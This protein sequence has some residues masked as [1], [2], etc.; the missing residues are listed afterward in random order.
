[1]RLFVN[2]IFRRNYWLATFV[3]ILFGFVWKDFATMSIGWTLFG[4]IDGIERIHEYE[5]SQV[6]KRDA[7]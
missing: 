3:F 1:M 7:R 4:M 5:R 2:N 6:R